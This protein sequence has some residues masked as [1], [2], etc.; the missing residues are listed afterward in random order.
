MYITPYQTSAFGKFVFDKTGSVVR[1]LEI[2]EQLIKLDPSGKILAIPRSVVDI[3]PFTMWLTKEEI[4]GLKTNVVVD[5]RPFLKE[6]GTSAKADVSNFY[7]L[8]GGLI[9][10]WMENG[11]SDIR[12]VG[13]DFLI[14]LYAQWMRNGLTQRL[15]LDFSQTYLVQA[16]MTIFYLQLHTPLT[17]NSSGQEVDRILN[18]AARTLPSTDP[19]TL[20][21]RLG[22]ELV[23]LNTLEEA[24]AWCREISESPRMEGLT[25]A[26]ARTVVGRAWPI[27][28]REV[29]NAAVEYPPL[30]AAMV[31]HSLKSR[32]FIRTE[33]GDMIKKSVR[34]QD[35]TN[36][37]N[38]MDRLLKG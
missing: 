36:F 26:L 27:Q 12:A 23:P 35:A 20:L 22:G 13:G 9:S 33:L 11:S 17:T 29:S 25:L 37:T 6:D 7:I 34:P 19:M 32:G 21:D 2:D 3:P 15:G 8:G 28:Y 4:P 24:L 5:G 1:R 30:F 31:Y 10:N 16:V 18:R 38:S 14:K